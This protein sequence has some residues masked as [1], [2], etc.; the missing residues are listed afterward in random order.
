MVGFNPD[1]G[2]KG[3][4]NNIPFMSDL[5][6]SDFIVKVLQMGRYSLSRANIAVHPLVQWR[7][8]YV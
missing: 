2:V 3:Y 5:N 1:T 7:N 8:T 4:V 6:D